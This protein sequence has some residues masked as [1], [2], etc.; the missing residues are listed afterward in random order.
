MYIRRVRVEL[1]KEGRRNRLFSE[2]EYL[3]LWIKIIK[4][5][6]S[7]VILFSLEKD[8]HCIRLQGMVLNAEEI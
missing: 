7:F 6:D 5:G 3:D 2:N 1:P 4:F 8:T